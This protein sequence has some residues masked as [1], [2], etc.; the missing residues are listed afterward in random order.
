MHHSYIDHFAQNDSVIHRLDARAK[1]LAVIA[2]TAVLISFD[3][4]V[5]SALAPLTVAPLAMLW[6]AR[7]PVCPLNLTL[8]VICLAMGCS[9]RREGYPREHT[10]SKVA[11]YAPLAR[12]PGRLV[13]G[14]R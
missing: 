4:Y 7:V 3:R 5:V 13:G 2:Y 10:Q 11:T 6:L 14:P 8:L 12:A 1:L 9:L